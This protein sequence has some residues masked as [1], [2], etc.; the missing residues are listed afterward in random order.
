MTYLKQRSRKGA[1]T[2]LISSR[3]QQ[4]TIEF[5]DEHCF[6]FGRF[7]NTALN[8]FVHDL[9]VDYNIKQEIYWLTQ[10]G[11]GFT[12]YKEDYR[13]SV[14][15]MIRVRADLIEYLKLNKYQVNTAINLACDRW[16]EYFK[17]GNVSEWKII[18]LID[19]KKKSVKKEEK[20]FRGTSGG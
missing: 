13:G 10:S 9:Q 3:I 4:H 11:R 8:T 6:V 18:D 1:S 5:A 16:R 15:K 17:N 12:G 2:I 14:A 7:I 19:K 20:P